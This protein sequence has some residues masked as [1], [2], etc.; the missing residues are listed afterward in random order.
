MNNF[1]K[2]IE[3]LLND[4]QLCGFKSNY[5][6]A[7]NNLKK[8]LINNNYNENNLTK[9]LVEKWLESL[10]DKKHNTLMYYQNFIRQLGLSMNKYGKQAYI[11]PCFEIGKKDNFI[12]HI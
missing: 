2:D 7:I 4:K 6:C 8:F 3:N 1:D 5:S 9:E 12:P 11:L 10:K